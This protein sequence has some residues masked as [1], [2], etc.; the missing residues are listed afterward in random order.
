LETTIST[1]PWFV[2]DDKASY[3]DEVAALGSRRCREVEEGVEEPSTS[4]GR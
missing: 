3:L 4:S 1:S 2:L